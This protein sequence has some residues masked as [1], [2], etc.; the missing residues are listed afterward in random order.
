MKKLI[1]A[2]IAC[3]MLATA[4]QAGLVNDTQD[5]RINAKWTYLQ[6]T[7]FN[8]ASNGRAAYVKTGYLQVG[9]GTPGVTPGNNDLFVVGTAEFDGVAQ[10]D[11]TTI[12][13]RGITYT[14]PTDDGDA[15]EQLQTNGSGVLTW[16]A[17]GAA[18][19][20]AWDD[21]GNPDANNSIDFTTYT[22]EFTCATTAG[23][24]F[25]FTNT[26]AF[27][28]IDVV[29]IAQNTGNPTDGTVLKVSAADT[30]VD[31]IVVTNTTAD[32]T[33][34]NALLRLDFTDDG[35][36]D[37]SYIICRDNAAADTKFS[38]GVDGNTTVAG[39]LNVTGAATLGS[40]TYTTLYTPTIVAAAAGNVALAIDAAGNGAI[41][42]GATSTG[43]VTVTPA[44][45]FSG[46]VDIGDAATDTLTITSIIDG[47]VTLD[48]NAGASPSLILKDATD[49]T[50]TFSKVDAG[51]LTLTT[52]AGDG[53]QVTTGNLKVGNG[54]PGVAQDG[55]DLYVN[56]VL[57][58][59]GA[60]YFDGAATVAGATTLNGDVAITDQI[61]QTLGD[62]A[63]ET[64][65]T[66]AVT[67]YA[68]DSALA[69]IRTTGAGATNNTYLLRLRNNA[70][71]DD[72]D[73]F[74]VLEDNNGDDKVAFNS[75]GTTTWTLD[76]ASLLTVNASTTANTTTGGVIDL[77]LASATTGGD[78]INVKV[79]STVGA[80]ET[81]SAYVADLDDDTAAAGSIYAYY[82]GASD[83]T[84]SSELLGFA[85]VGLD[86]DFYSLKAAAATSLH[87]DGNTTDS[88]TTTGDVLIDIGTVTNGNIGQLIDYNVGDTG[89]G[90]TATALKVD[91]DDDTA[92][93]AATIRG[94]SAVASDAAGHASTVIQGFYTSGCEAA[95]QAD[96]GYVR[97][98]TGST[99]DITLGDD[100]L[101]VEGSAE[102]DGQ[103]S[104]VRTITDDA[105]GM[106]QGDFSSAQSVG[107]AITNAGAGGAMVYNLPAAVAG[108]QYTFVVMAAQNMDINPDAADQILV[109]TN[110]VGDAIRSATAGNTVTL[111]A[112]DA[113]NWVVVGEK[114]TWADVN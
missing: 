91:L 83:S 37:G 114:G 88:T 39:T 104:I 45:V 6:P 5:E 36:S 63:E 3:L 46:N 22:Q 74:L 32:L 79:V 18:A 99:P 16:E 2:L 34:G 66:T 38:V 100:V 77:D 64:I 4:A 94:Y 20:T 44:A 50:A 82:A 60:A 107:T 108:L 43:T 111:L 15:S 68:A 80:G 8:A 84:G 27:G 87:I 24:A 92:A 86:K 102:F 56:D 72:Q 48:D 17:A 28:N 112:V 61:L 57:E 41:G 75:G 49:E 96:N 54:V 109:L 76:A 42:I 62:N 65:I 73:H 58:V 26:G 23:D 33:A 97:V 103:V 105:D 12:K 101:Y 19:F 11:A 35:D 13:L 59:D 25:T 67:D 81:T 9:Q 30:D 52:V 53:L 7:E 93:N 29:E 21:I 98:G 69:T 31:G 85:S 70:D 71:A 78:G 14:L 40:V 110:A 89:A 47:D 106:A 55:E 51:F 10:F 113:T 1:F 90:V 95:L